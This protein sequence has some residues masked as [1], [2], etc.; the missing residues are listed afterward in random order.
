MFIIF[1]EFFFRV[2][3]LP[4]GSRSPL[5]YASDRNIKIFG[6]HFDERAANWKG[7]NVQQ[8]Q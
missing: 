4:T 1:F 2:P 3:L 8:S 6:E 5:N 7:D